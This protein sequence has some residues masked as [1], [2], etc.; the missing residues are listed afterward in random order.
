MVQPKQPRSSKDYQRCYIVAVFKVP[1][2]I[3]HEVESLT[4]S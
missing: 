1:D 3:S 4:I 2:L